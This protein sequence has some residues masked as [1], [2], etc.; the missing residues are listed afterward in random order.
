M[1]CKQRITY[2]MICT[3]VSYTQQSWFLR[4]HKQ[5]EFA[6][7][8]PPVGTLIFFVTPDERH[9][10]P[11]QNTPKF[12]TFLETNTMTVCSYEL[13]CAGILFAQFPV[14]TCLLSQRRNQP[15]V[16]GPRQFNTSLTSCHD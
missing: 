15:D 8:S 16:V 10:S 2:C 1:K 13:T 12:S 4:T 5:P 11:N 7:R 6:Y 9:D 14:R 3:Y